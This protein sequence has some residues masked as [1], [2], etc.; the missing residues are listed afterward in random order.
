MPGKGSITIAWPKPATI[1]RVVWGRD[2]EEV[3]RDRLA[4]EYY[5]EVALEPG[6]WQVVASSL[7]RV[8][9][10]PGAAA[11]KPT[12]SIAELTPEL[13]KERAGLTARQGELRARLSQVGSALKVY[14]GTFTEPGST[15]LLVRG[16]PTRKGAVIGPATVASIRPGLSIDARLP[17]A[18]RRLAL[19]QWI[20]DPANPLPARVMV[21]RVWHYHF[22]R[23]IVATPSDFGFNGAAPSH[24]ELLDWLASTYIAGGWRLKPI[25]RL[26]VTSSV[27]RQSSRLDPRA[28]A[29]DRDNR[30]L[31]RMTPRRLE[32]ESLRDAILATSGQ[33]DTRMGG[34]GYN[35]WEPNTN[36][37]AVYKPRTELGYDAFRRMVY[38]FKPRSQPDP[39]F[40]AFD[41]PDA[42][43]VAPRRNVSTTALQALNLLNS[44]FV[45]QQAT[46]LARRL[47]AESGPDPARQVE[48]AF[49]LAFGARLF[50]SS[51]MPLSR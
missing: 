16:D 48:L 17:E 14:A 24:P 44:R 2:R 51:A 7:D 28:Q 37:V 31:W 45:I 12:G 42:A 13:A 41:C 20:A 21:N 29:V 15:Y 47:E 46:C 36:Y 43:L 23:G 10:D 34:P 22:G 11:A 33:L 32:A 35:I 18:Q 6:Q 8:R 30:L 5:L 40:S 4:T 38:Q 27:Y 39:T 25:H 26:I 50:P 19:A 49:R 9:F 3:Y 1:D